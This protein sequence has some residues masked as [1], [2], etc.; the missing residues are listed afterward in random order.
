LVYRSPDGHVCECCR[1]GIAVKG[2]NVAIMFRN[3]LNGSR[4]LYLAT[5]TDKGKTFNKA[6]KLGNDT[7]KMN[8]CTMDGGGL[9]FNADNTIN[10]TWQRKGVV[11]YCTPGQNEKELGKGRDCSISADKNQIL[12]AMGDG[13]RLTYK[14]VQTNKETYV[15]K[16][17]YLKTVILPDSKV[18]CVWEDGPTIKTIKL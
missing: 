8:S 11:Y 7:W 18:L 16:G 13:G 5:S 14:N 2:G 9:D 6:T 15:G 1:P 17:S 10:T 4:D 3:W 12:V